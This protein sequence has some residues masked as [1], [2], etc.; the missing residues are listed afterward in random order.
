MNTDSKD[1]ATA[2]TPSLFPKLYKYIQGV[3]GADID[4]LRYYLSTPVWIPSLCAAV[5]HASVLTYSGTLITYL[6]NSGFPLK[7]VT[8]ARFT[9]AVFEIGSTFVYPW[10][11]RVLSKG[12]NRTAVRYEMAPQ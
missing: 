4:G 8:I 7:A 10:A 5:P 9:G 3:V 1:R 6:L 12:H 2:R 11:V